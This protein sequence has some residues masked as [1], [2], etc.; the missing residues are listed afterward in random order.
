MRYEI[1]S[2][3]RDSLF[4]INNIGYS[5]DTA[6][7][8]FGPGRRDLYIIHYVLSGSGFFNG[9]K[10]SG[11]Q[12]FLITP[13]MPEHY[14]PSETDPWSF[15]WAVFTDSDA[16]KLFGAY[17]A[18]PKTHIFEY[19]NK[20]ALMKT[21]TLLTHNSKRQYNSAELF[22]V[23]LHIFNDHEHMR[24]THQKAADLYCDHAVNYIHYHLFRPITVE[25]LTD[26][27][28]VTQPYLYHIFTEKYGMSPK[29][30]ITDCK[31]SKAKQLLLETN[32]PVCEVAASVGYPDALC[33]SKQFKKFAGCSPKDFR[34]RR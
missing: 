23:Y 6:V 5:A 17:H 16:E 19:G 2:C 27:L 20:Q 10:V 31:L 12:G 7:T 34:I 9:Q 26:L 15:L 8:R 25:E 24:K 21:V 14:Y 22:E 11:G 18:D 1:I 33:F 32:L 30:Y 29:R 3:D 13:G 4:S 28:G